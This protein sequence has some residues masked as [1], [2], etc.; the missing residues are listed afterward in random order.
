[1]AHRARITRFALIVSVLFAV[2]TDRAEACSCLGGLPICQ[3]LWTTPAVF[4]ALV[5]EVTPVPNR[6]DQDFMPQRIARLQVEQAWKGNASGIV[7]VSTGSGG[8]DCG[9]DLVVGTRYLIYAHARDGRLVVSICS[10]TKPLAE[11]AEDLAYLKTAFQPSAVGRVLGAV[12]YQRQKPE[13]PDRPIA[14]YG[15]LLRGPDREW[16]ATTN[17]AGRYEF[18][19][20]AGKYQIQ[21]AVPPTEHAYGPREVELADSRGCVTGDFTV[22]PDGRIV[23][24]VIDAD[25]K[26]L[27][28][29]RVEFVKADTLTPSRMYADTRMAMS[30][31]DGRAEARQLQP[32]RYVIGINVNQPPD[33][34]QPYPRLFYPG[35]TDPAAAHVVDLQAGERVELEPFVLPPSLVE[36]RISGV[37][38]WPDGSAAAGANVSLLTERGGRRF[39]THVGTPV[40]ADKDGRFTLLALAGRRYH[41]SAFIDVKTSDGKRI[42]WTADSPDFDADAV[43]GPMVL[44]LAAPGAR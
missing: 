21:L 34:K 29:L 40:S 20:P 19:V 33:T 30:D 16:K 43:A 12:R 23:T 41:L 4:S 38:Q 36:R 42:Q 35:V 9:Y 44:T 2:S 8:G 28:G 22:V 13:D 6:P 37:V 18:S 39:G 3:S 1:M 14:G 25:G 26:P 32:E 10:R 27:T 15:V 17:A 24:R 7:E 11:A 31:A 5:L